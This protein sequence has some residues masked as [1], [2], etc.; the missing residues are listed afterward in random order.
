MELIEDDQL[1]E[2]ALSLLDEYNDDNNARTQEVAHEKRTATKTKKKRNYNPNRARAA[3]YKELQELRDQVPMLERRLK[4][5]QLEIENT[6]PSTMTV[7]KQQTMELWKKMAMYQRQT[8]LSSE[9]ENRRLRQLIQ[10]HNEITTRNIQQLLQT[11]QGHV[12]K[13]ERLPDPWPCRRQYPVPMGS[14]DSALFRDMAGTIDFVHRQVLRVFSLCPGTITD[15]TLF[16]NAKNAHPRLFADRMFPFSVE[17]T[18][19]AAWQY[20][21]HSFRRPTTRFYYHV[22]STQSSGIVRDDTIVE[23][24]GE[25]H[26]FGKVL[27]DFKVKQIVRRYEVAGRVVVAW[28]AILSPDKFKGESLGGVQFEEKGAL[29]VEPYEDQL[30][31]SNQA[32]SIVHTWQTIT[33]D[34]NDIAAEGDQKKLVQDM[35][36]FVLNGCLPSRAFDF[37]DRT[38]RAQFQQ[39]PTQLNGFTP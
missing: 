6:D 2:A 38:L 32:A 25:E 4:M 35:T 31:G 9:E 24:F 33:G 18:G 26:R 37:M 15:V 5:L 36:E 27:L 39:G 22:E 21:A 17:L 14:N 29:V 3:Q 34:I 7:G 20:F 12:E 16:P 30:L 11:R 23:S 19:D 10:E 28:R 8:R 1:L 13:I